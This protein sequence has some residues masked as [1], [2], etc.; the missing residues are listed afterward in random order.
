MSFLSKYISK[1]MVELFHQ[2]IETFP[3]FFI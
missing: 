2:E 1:N 3:D